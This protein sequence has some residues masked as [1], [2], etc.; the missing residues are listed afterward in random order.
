[1]TLAARQKAPPPLNFVT[2][3]GG[4]VQ[5]EQGQFAQDVSAQLGIPFNQLSMTK[6]MAW[7]QQEGGHWHN[8]ARYNPLNTTLAMPGA[9]NTGTQGNIKVYTSWAQG[10][11]ATAQTLRSP[12][13]KGVIANLSGNGNLASFEGAVNA[14]PWGTKFPG[15]GKGG[16]EGRG[17]SS[18]PGG[19]TNLPAD[20]ASAAAAAKKVATSIPDA[21]TGA[22]NSVKT[23]L[24]SW[25]LKVPL[26]I[27]AALLMIYGVMVAVRPRESA[28]SLPRLPVPVPV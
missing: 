21:I 23:G 7:M 12:A 17:P 25:A 28:M 22:V 19:E 11:A 8:S 9:G 2:P 5:L 13:Y 26:L 18:I 15:G 16:G 4:N 1:M 6:L 24:I 27:A 3:H 20:A 10:V 14:T